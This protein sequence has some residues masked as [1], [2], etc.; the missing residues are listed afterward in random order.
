MVEAEAAK[1]II[2]FLR[3]VVG[4]I[5]VATIALATTTAAAATTASAGAAF[6]VVIAAA[7]G[8]LAAIAIG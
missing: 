8:A 1:I 2:Q 6:I 5:R 7:L 3:G 4:G